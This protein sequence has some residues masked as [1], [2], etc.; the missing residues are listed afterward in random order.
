ML[1]EQQKK[2]EQEKK[3][4]YTGLRT[5]SAECAREQVGDSRSEKAARLTRFADAS[6]EP[7]HCAKIDE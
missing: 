7:G 5:R 1:L 2:R 4:K 3:R 6:M